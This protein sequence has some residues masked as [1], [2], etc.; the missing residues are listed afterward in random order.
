MRRYGLARILA[1]ALAAS[2]GVSGATY[3]PPNIV[4]IYPDDQGY[5][6]VSYLNP[7]PKFQTPNIDRLIAGGINFTHGHSA[8]SACT[9]SRYAL[10]T[11]LHQKVEKSRSLLGM[12]R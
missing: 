9:P 12:R 5:A 7:A 10:I 3:V 4:I 2:S 11:G 1:I 6:D 8:G